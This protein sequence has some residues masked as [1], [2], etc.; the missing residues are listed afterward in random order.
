VTQCE[1]APPAVFRL[2]QPVSL[3][4]P[5]C[6]E[7]DV[8]REVIEE[9]H[10]DVIEELP[11]GSELVLDDGDSTDGTLEILDEMGRR[12]PY[13]R[14]IR[15][16]RDGFGASA[17]RLFQA[18]RCPLV[19]FTDS[20][21]QYVPSEFWR[22]TEHIG[23]TDLVHGA[24]GCRQ[25]PVFRRIASWGFNRLA[26]WYFGVRISDINS[27]FRLM[28]REVVADLLPKTRHMPTLL[29][30]E[31]LLRAVSGGYSVR[32]VAVAHRQRRHGGS[33]GLPP[34]HFLEE[35]W[36]TYVGLVRLQ[37]ELRTQGRLDH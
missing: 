17:R 22:L 32:E 24:K 15:S 30:A 36:R 3:L 29:N 19:F 7:S 33:R 31:M 14:V 4:M 35:C 20:D 25:D 23:G 16:K 8:I 34:R 9:W 28:R 6:N 18:A 21:G 5:V 10:R 13:L 11:D 12:L 37:R 1:A 2:A 27:A 26:R